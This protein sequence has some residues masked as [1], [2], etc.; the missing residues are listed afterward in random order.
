[1]HGQ[2]KIGNPITRNLIKIKMKTTEE[3]LEEKR[4]TLSEIETTLKMSTDLYEITTSEFGQLYRAN[5]GKDV[6]GQV[7]AG[8]ASL[9]NRIKEMYETRNSIQNEINSLLE[10]DEE[11]NKEERPG[12]ITGDKETILKLMSGGKK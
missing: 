4:Q 12:Q 9:L 10:L 2:T 7:L 1:M 6:S 5:K 8:I 3:K 11:N